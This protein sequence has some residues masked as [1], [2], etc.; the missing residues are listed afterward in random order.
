METSD[1]LPGINAR[2]LLIK[3]TIIIKIWNWHEG[4]LYK[5]EHK[6]KRYAK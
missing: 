3:N 5:G 2:K 1:N 6:N 4:C